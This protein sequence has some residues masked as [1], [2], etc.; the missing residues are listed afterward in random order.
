VP[1]PAA[2]DAF[3]TYHKQAGI[4]AGPL[5]DMVHQHM[6]QYFRYRYQARNDAAG[7]AAGTSYVTRKFFRQAGVE[8]QTLR[9]TQQH[10]VAIL[11][12]VV[13]KLDHIM[14]THASYDTYV[15][16]PF[17][18][19]GSFLPLLAIFD[20]EAA[21]GA[22][23]IVLRDV[24]DNGDRDRV[25]GKAP[26]KLRQWRKWLADHLSPDLMDEDAPERDVLSMVET[27]SDTPLPKEM[28]GFFDDMVHDSMAGLAK[29]G[30]NEFLAINGIGIGKF[31][32]IYFGNHG[33]AMLRKAAEERNRQRAKAAEA[34]RA[35]RRQNELEA[36]EFARTR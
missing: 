23:A 13:A 14:K 24:S 11:A 5:E 7:N 9:D 16:H 30:V 10:F 32:R 12:G 18:S 21:M 17:Q 35:R 3:N 2:I 25:A 31:R 34:Q 29:Q 26:E 36:Q 20:Y 33:D 8:R 15:S 19:E 22:R 28:T 6:V 27:L 1:S 4:T